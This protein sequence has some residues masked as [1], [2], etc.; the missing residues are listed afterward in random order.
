MIY[1]SSISTIIFINFVEFSG[2]ETL[3]LHNAWWEEKHI[4]M[5]R[6]NDIE[7]KIIYSLVIVATYEA[8]HDEFHS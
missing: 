7:E 3:L 1:P 4:R 8:L 2:I 6:S 5:I